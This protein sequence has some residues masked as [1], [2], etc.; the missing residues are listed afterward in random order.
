SASRAE[1]VTPAFGAAMQV[2]EHKCCRDDTTG[3]APKTRLLFCP[4]SPVLPA[5]IFAFPKDGNYDLTKPS[6]AHRRARRDRHE[7]RARD[8][9]DAVLPQDV[10]RG[11]VRSSRVVLIPRRWDQV[12]RSRV[13][14]RRR[15]ESPVSGESTE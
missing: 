7:R 14:S 3:K 8:A 2:A 1:A 13:G 11:R 6:R 10:R 12:C 15:Q 5:K 4:T 9:M